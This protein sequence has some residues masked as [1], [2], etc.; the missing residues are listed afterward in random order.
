MAC[1]GM[2]LCH[3]KNAKNRDIKAKQ[4]KAKNVI[5]QRRNNKSK[6]NCVHVSACGMYM[7]C[8]PIHIALISAIFIR[9]RMELITLSSFKHIRAGR[10][11]SSK[12]A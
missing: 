9:I 2:R 7:F 4:S 12:A 6:E 11:M 3:H 5:N 10:A 1:V 8:K